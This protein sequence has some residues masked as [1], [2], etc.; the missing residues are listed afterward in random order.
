MKDPFSNHSRWR[1]RRLTL[2]RGALSVLLPAAMAA[3]CKPEPAHAPV[4]LEPDRIVII[5]GSIHLDNGEDVAYRAI[6]A[7]DPASPGLH[8]GT[9]DIPMQAL[10]GAS[11]DWAWFE[12]GDRIEF[13]LAQPGTPRWTGRYEAG[14]SIACEFRQAALWLPCTMRDVSAHPGAARALAG[15]GARPAIER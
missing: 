15:E 4:T 8:L 2:A 1:E 13:T 11:L 12:A 10:S 6:L 9:I 7:P 5:E 3:A 14:G